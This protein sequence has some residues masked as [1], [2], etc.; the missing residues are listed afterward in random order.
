MPLFRSA[1]LLATALLI[2]VGLGAPPATAQAVQFIQV[3]AQPDIRSARQRARDFARNFAGVRAF[4]TPTGWYAVSIGPID[5]GIAEDE[6]ARLVR[7]GV[8]PPDSFLSDGTD[9]V[10]QVWPADANAG[11]S[12]RAVAARVGTGTDTTGGSISITDDGGDDAGDGTQ[13]QASATVVAQAEDVPEETPAQARALERRLT[14]EEKMAIQEA[15]VWTGDYQSKIDGAFGRGT[16]NAISQYQERMGYEVTGYLTTRQI[17][18]LTGNYLA[19]IAR[20]GFR[21]FRDDAAGIEVQFPTALVEF[22]KYEPPFVHYRPKPGQKVR[23]LLISQEGDRNVLSALYDIMET[24]EIVPLEGYRTRK[25]D[26][27]V[28]SGRNDEIVSYT[29]ARHENGFIKG[30]TL[31]WPPEMDDPMERVAVAMFNT[32][33]S[34]GDYALDETLGGTSEDRIDLVSGLEIRQPDRTASGVFVSA[35]GAVLTAATNVRNCQRITVAPDHRM[36]VA[37]ADE[38]ADV[39]LLTPE[40]EIEPLDYARFAAFMPRVRDRVVVSGYS[41]GG[42]LGAPTQTW[43]TLEDKMGLN[44]EADLARLNIDV[45]PGDFGG[46]VFDVDG[47]LVGLLRPRDDSGS[48][49]LPRDVNFATRA[50]AILAALEEHGV[51][52]ETTDQPIVQDTIALTE[53]TYALTAEVNCWN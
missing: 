35:D 49:K 8:I 46:P 15:L 53:L 31:I 43:G 17:N 24:L 50:D 36:S 9:Y 7:R 2:A 27:F 18:E 37:W 30:F 25:K 33:K 38:A 23:V 6:L 5:A 52:V 39:A 14:R 28:L 1:F 20:L 16:R 26:F 11:A 41:F 3:E 21:T 13:D 32:L 51:R 44:G 42:T 22:D 29:F 19:T 45:L 4:R 40:E 48:R 47:R 34:T 12:G 10:S